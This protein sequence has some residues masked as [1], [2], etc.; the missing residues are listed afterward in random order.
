VVGAC[1]YSSR[2]GLKVSN[3]PGIF[4]PDRLAAVGKHLAK[5]YSAGR[6][7]FDDLTDVSLHYDESVV[8][9]R[10][11]QKNLLVFVVCD[12]TFNHNLL[13]MSL[14]LLQEEVANSDFDAADPVA[15]P[16]LQPAAAVAYQPRPEG[17]LQGLFSEMKELLGK[18]LGPMAGFIF[19]EMAE[20]W[21]KQGAA[22]IGRIDE[23]IELLNREISDPDK[24]KHYRKLIEP[25]LSNFRKG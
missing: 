2:A 18:V 17:Q 23:L 1:I 7:S 6:M 8:V 16:A 25:E 19:D 20:V 11:L 10:E 24:I 14:N 13:T 9:A 3:L 21:E 4:K 5:L 12:P 22:E 15:T